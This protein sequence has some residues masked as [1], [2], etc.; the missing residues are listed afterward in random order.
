MNKSEKNKFEMI[1]SVANFG[2]TENTSI[3]TMPALV[4]EFSDLEMIHKE[5]GLN[6]RVLE[7]GTKGK[8]VS[9]NISQA[10][11]VKTGLVFAGAIYGYAAAKE[12]SELMT[13]ADVS[14]VTLK[15]L[16]DS[17]VPLVI[18]RF[19]DKADELGNELAAYGIT[20]EKR[21]AARRQLNN[22]LD[23]FSE[24]STGKGS[25]KTARQNITLLFN[26][27]DKKLKVI[28]KLMLGFKVSNPELYS[29]Y[30]AARVIYD[31]G[32]GHTKSTPPTTPV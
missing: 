7:E 4:P 14:S 2:K 20:E 26:K 24:L 21:T 1:G 11:I 13:F 17:E 30:E 10:E 15:R 22:Y 32:I 5:I 9:K 18:E 23:D 27:A 16:R 25:K 8:V 6:D 12:D 3:A 29:K 19:L 28:D 31:K